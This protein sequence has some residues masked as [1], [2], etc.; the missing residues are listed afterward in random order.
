MDKLEIGDVEKTKVLLNESGEIKSII[1][2]IC[3]KSQNQMTYN[4]TQGSSHTFS[5][6]LYTLYLSSLS[7]EI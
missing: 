5:F 4:F 3:S 1:G 7:L 6:I 2:A